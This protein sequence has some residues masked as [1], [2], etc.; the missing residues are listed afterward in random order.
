[1]KIYLEINK[2]IEEIRFAAENGF[3]L[4][5]SWALF[6]LRLRSQQ[7]VE[8]LQTRRNDTFELFS[9]IQNQFPLLSDSSNVWHTKNDPRRI[10]N[11]TVQFLS[12]SHAQFEY[13][14]ELEFV[15]KSRD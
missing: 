13:L 12:F 4:G 3:V 5:L 7:A 10:Q 1:M 9:E 14:I 6:L 11:L 2:I 15:Q 8:N